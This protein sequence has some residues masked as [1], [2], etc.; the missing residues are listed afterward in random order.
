MKRGVLITGTSHGL[1]RVIAE[2]FLERGALVFG[3]SRGVCP[4]IHD[5]YQHFTLDIGNEIQVSQ[6]FKNIK[7]TQIPLEV[8]INNAGILYS[9]IASFT[10]AAKFKEVIDVN[11]IGTFLITRETLKLMYRH[12]F[13]RII[14]FSSINVEAGWAGGSAY[15]ASK[16]GVAA[17]SKSLTRECMGADIT[18]NTLGLSFAAK[19]GM[20]DDISPDILAQ[21]QMELI[22]PDLLEVDEIIHAIDFFSSRLA[23]NISCQTM[24]FGG[25]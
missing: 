12:K 4:I 17:M 2:K 11:L 24:Y 13:G 14:N 6:M 20:M 16:A 1:G 21:K 15:N 23:K 18:I 7:S 8:L 3:C 10:S 5:N 25:I 19:G 22:K 9:G